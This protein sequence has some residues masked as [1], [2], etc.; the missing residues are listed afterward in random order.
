MLT[1][2]EMG[3]GLGFGSLVGSR[4]GGGGGIL[5]MQSISLRSEHTSVCN[6]SPETLWQEDERSTEH[7]DPSSHL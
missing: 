6:S 4:G 7:T 3:G 2:S 5:V 1:L